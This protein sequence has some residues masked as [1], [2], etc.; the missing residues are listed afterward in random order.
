MCIS[1][2]KMGYIPSHEVVLF[3]FLFV[4]CLFENGGTQTC[5]L[6]REKLI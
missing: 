1:K 3:F 5:S 6:L 2:K 4:V